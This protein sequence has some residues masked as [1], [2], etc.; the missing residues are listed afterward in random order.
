MMAFMAFALSLGLSMM[1]A[2]PNPIMLIGSPINTLSGCLSSFQIEKETN[3]AGI[4]PDFERGA[5]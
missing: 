1:E 5:S 3:Q 4:G 2:L